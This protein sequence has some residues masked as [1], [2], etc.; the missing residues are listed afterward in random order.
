MKNRSDRCK[1]AAIGLAAAVATSFAFAGQAQAQF[2]GPGIYK[3][4]VAG[5][6]QVLDIDSGWGH[7]GWPGQRLLR[8]G[9]ND[10]AN[11][12]F[13]IFED[14]DGYVIRPLHSLMC[15]DFP[16]DRRDPGTEIQ[17]LG[18]NRSQAQRFYIA[19]H[20]ARQTLIF[21]N[22][23][24]DTRLYAPTE[25]QRVVLTPRRRGIPYEGGTLFEFERM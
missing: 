20:G 15:L 7:G 16:Y 8:W 10:G 5:T 14:G 1:R 12:R 4:R 3:I 13:I 6:N 17:Q 18:C 23:T 24:G 22:W 21:G 25:G 19:S 2:T 11:Q 9:S